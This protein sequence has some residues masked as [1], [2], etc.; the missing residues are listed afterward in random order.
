[1]DM[2]LG[3]IAGMAF[4]PRRD[5]NLIHIPVGHLFGSHVTRLGLK[6]GVFVRDYLYEFVTMC[7]SED[8]ARDALDD[9]LN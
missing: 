1:L 9:M 3:I 8:L 7:S 5:A 4:D 6:K 2:G